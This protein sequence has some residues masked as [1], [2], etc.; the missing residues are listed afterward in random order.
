MKMAEK[1]VDTSSPEYQ[2]DTAVDSSSALPPPPQEVSDLCKETFDKMSDYLMGELTMTVED[3]SLLEQMNKV[4]MN[5]YFEMKQM[6]A[7][8]STAMQELNDK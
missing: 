1:T 5:K 7:N 3:Y 2:T 8:I 6:T 4:T